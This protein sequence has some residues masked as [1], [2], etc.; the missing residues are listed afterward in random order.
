MEFSKKYEQNLIP[1][2][3]AHCNSVRKNLQKKVIKTAKNIENEKFSN[4]FLARFFFGIV[5]HASSYR[6]NGE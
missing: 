1:N 4:F 3:R 5:S 2:D 6:K